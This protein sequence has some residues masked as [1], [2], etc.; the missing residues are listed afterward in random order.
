MSD[1]DPGPRPDPQI[2]PGEPDPGG[3]D[4]VTDS[5]GVDG[6]SAEPNPLL[7]DLDPDDNPSTGDIPME[8]KQGE[9][10]DTEGTRSEDAG[11]EAPPEEESPA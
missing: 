11:E 9:D 5:D 8:T 10:T 3:V 2:E 4:A 7:R 6:E 1:S